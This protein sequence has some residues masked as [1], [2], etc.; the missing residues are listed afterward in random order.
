[1]TSVLIPVQRPSP[2]LENCLRHLIDH[3]PGCGD[4][5]VVD[6]TAPNACVHAICKEWKHKC[7]ALHHLRCDEPLDSIGLCRWA[8]RTIQKTGSDLWIIDPAVAIGPG[9][10][11]ELTAVLRLYE[12]HA[13]AV[14]RSNRP[15]ISAIPL[16]GPELPPDDAYGVWQ[17]LRNRLPRYQIVPSAD[18]VCM[19]IRGE[20]LRHFGFFGAGENEHDYSNRINR[21]G[22]STLLA[23]RAFVR[24]VAQPVQSPPREDLSSY[25]ELDA[26]P[27]DYFGALAI[28]HRPRILFDLSHLAPHYYGTADFAL[29]L[30]RDL[31]AL[32][33]DEIE[34]Y[35]DLQ[36]ASFAFFL[37]ELQGYPLYRSAVEPA[38][39]FDLVFKPTQINSWQELERINR[40]AP[41]IA[42]TI[43]DMIAVRCGYLSAPGRRLLFQTTAEICDRVFTLSH[44]VKADFA[45]LTGS[46]V[47]LNVVHLGTNYGVSAHECFRGTYVLLMGNSYAHKNIKEAL[48]ALAGEP[49]PIVVLGGR[50]PDDGAVLNVRYLESGGLSRE[51]VRETLA[52]AR[53]VVYPSHYEG[54][55]L[56]V[57]D[58]LALRKPVIVLDNAT[59]QELAG[60]TGD[61]NLRRIPGIEALSG[62]IRQVWDDVSNR[63]PV[64]PRRWR[65][66]AQEYL[67]SFHELLER[68]VD[69]ARLRGRWKVLR[70]RHA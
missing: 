6:G 30:L 14:S 67:A 23:N 42:Y 37:P 24:I 20:V 43:L 62:A 47:S 38:Q 2:D 64:S 4:V 19:L 28:P 5:Y 22:Y 44:S 48:S 52:G 25:L 70:V 49:W 29:N 55:G 21:Y 1:M 3:A 60:L 57:L 12:R 17:T 34:F 41:R 18:A 32:A 10:L 53:V 61:A 51:T 59:N 50:A 66:A 69:T 68:D 15:G 65:T 31:H 56:P 7:P 13:V 11:E 16:G 63:E 40:L 35:I 58:A 8:Y 27:V 9:V 39:L 26:D 33:G 36:P 45:A 54:F 46:E